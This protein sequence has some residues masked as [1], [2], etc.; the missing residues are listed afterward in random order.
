MSAGVHHANGNGAGICVECELPVFDRNHYFTGKFMVARDFTDEQRFLVGKD[1]RHAQRL[2]GWGTVCG[3]KV[4][5]HESDVC[6]DRWVVIEPG[7]AIDCCGREIVLVEREYFDFHTAFVDW[8]Q[9]EKGP[10][11]PPDDTPRRLQ[12]ALCYAE[13]PTEEVPALFDDCGC[14]DTACQPNRIKERFELV[15]RIDAE[16]APE[17]PLAVALKWG[18][19]VNVQRASRVRVHDDRLYVLGSEDGGQPWTLHL[20]ETEHSALLAP[21]KEFTE[22]A[23]DLA[24]APDGARAYVAVAGTGADGSI[25]VLDLA[26]D[27]L[28][29]VV[30]LTVPGAGADPVRL[31]VSPADGRIFALATKTGVVHAF[32]ATM[33]PAPAAESFDP[34][35]GA[36]DLAASTDGTS[37]YVTDGTDEVKTLDATN[38]ATAP[39]T[40]FTLGSGDA[41]L[42]HCY[43]TTAG[44]N[45]AVAFTD[46]TDEGIQLIGL[47]PGT[48]TPVVDLKTAPLAEPAVALQASPGGVH[49]FVLEEAADEKGTVQAVWTHRVELGQLDPVTAPVLVGER[50]RSLALSDDGKLLYAAFLMPLHEALFVESNPGPVKYAASKLGLCNGETR[51]PLAPIAAASRKRVDDALATV[52]LAL[53]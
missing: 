14:D 20:F 41:H 53:V 40:L 46:G 52:G 43:E 36:T 6:R 35:T 51:L 25:A 16:D 33:P 17:D 29:D 18:C 11:S 15:V 42:V 8:W 31:S 9:A 45:L 7:T 30:T 26:A 49:V 10:D 32:D 27:S 23:H 38:P 22:E 1:R 5:P 2:H 44:D 21:T 37:V 19:T 13:C 34:I 47:R 48:A 24:L 39:S 3:L 28:A 50:P 12:I 4:V